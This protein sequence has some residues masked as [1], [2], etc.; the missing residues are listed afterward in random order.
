MSGIT[1]YIFNGS[2]SGA[3]LFLLCNVPFVLTRLY[4]KLYPAPVPKPVTVMSQLDDYIQQNTSRFL[5]TYQ[6]NKSGGLNSNVNEEFYSKDAYQSIIKT[7]NNRLEVEWKRRLM[8]EYTPRGNVI[9]YYD[10][11]KLAFAYYCDTSSMPYNLLNAIAMKYV[12]S[13]HCMH[14]FVDN[15]VTPADGAS[16]LIAGLI[17][18]VPTEKS[19][20][21]DN[22]GGID[23]KNAPFAKFKKAASNPGNKDADKKP[24]II[25]NH[26]KFVCVGKIINFSFLRKGSAAANTINGFQSKLLD[27]LAAETTL[28]SQVM[29]YKDFKKMALS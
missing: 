21:K 2:Y 9:M 14:L 8:F 16:P 12:L 7:E 19:K 6:T 3:K 15:E 28:Q 22:V 5:R 13:F 17:A 27:N 20:K 29:S 4:Q 1:N 11:Y 25:Y 23:M 10:P 26:N 18:D 24:V